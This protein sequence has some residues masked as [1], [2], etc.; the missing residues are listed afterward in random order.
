V[1]LRADIAHA[2]ID[3]V[4]EVAEG[5]EIP[6]GE[7]GCKPNAI[8]VGTSDGQQMA[9]A[10]VGERRRAF[11]IGATRS[12]RG[13]RALETF[14]TSDAAVRWWTISFP[15]DQTGCL[16]IR[17]GDQRACANSF[18][19]S[20]RGQGVIDYL[21][22]AIV[23]LDVPKLSGTNVTV[24]SD[25]LAMVVLAQI[26]P[27]G[28]TGGFDTVL[29]AFDGRGVGDGLT[30]WDQA[31][32]DALYGAGEYRLNGPAQSDALAEIL[33]ERLGPSNGN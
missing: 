11:R 31:Y 28:D 4:S 10:L 33:A 8:I 14:R 2:I 6:L 27:E 26:D 30:D 29:N 13:S 23:I 25:Y 24:L 18:N 21:R 7:P 3:R 32:L 5:L 22:R 16:A 17:I 15:Y 20:Y 9:E 19:R 12:N 1:G